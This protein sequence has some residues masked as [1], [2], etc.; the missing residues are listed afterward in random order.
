MKLSRVF[1]AGALVA[2]SLP[3]LA[4]VA[5]ADG[6]PPGDPIYK[7]GGDPPLQGEQ[8]ESII[9]TE[10]TVAC[11][12]GTC[13]AEPNDGSSPCELI[14]FGGA[15]T[16]LSPSCF[17]QNDVATLGV[18]QIINALI[19]DLPG[20]APSATECGTIEGDPTLFGVCNVTSDGGTGTIVS[21]SDGT[22]AYGQD[23]FLDLEG[24]TGG[25]S[26]AV[27]AN[28]PEPGT[29]PMLGLGLVALV[30]LSRKRI[31]QQAR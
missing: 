8:P 17:F 18:G 1:V 22:I 10:F 12:S 30:A 25:I 23:F 16:Q 14:Q 3:M 4:A 28:V 5:K 21:F 15:S 26:S 27:Y 20:I 9:S 11:A 7:T 29:L 13:P 24:F 31:F 2:L 6:L 19:I